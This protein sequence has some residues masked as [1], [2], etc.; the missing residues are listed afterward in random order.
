MTPSGLIVNGKY[1]KA[2]RKAIIIF[3]IVVLYSFFLCYI[4][5]QSSQQHSVRLLEN[6]KEQNM[7]AQWRLTVRENWNDQLTHQR[8]SLLNIINK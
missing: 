2:M 8:D 1:N 6:C 3:V 5:A 4:V 7:E